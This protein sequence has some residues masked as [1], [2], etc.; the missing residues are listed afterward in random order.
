MVKNYLDVALRSCLGNKLFSFINLFGLAV[1][2]ASAILIGLYVADELSYDRFHP[3][4]ERV[5]RVGRDIYPRTDFGGLY[6]ATVPPIAAE[7]LQADFPEIELAARAMPI[8]GLLSRGDAEFYENSILYAD[9]EL[10]DII[11]FEW[12]AGDPATALDAP[13]A[14]VL[15]ETL[16]R[17]YFGDEEAFGR[18]LTLE[19]SEDL[20][21]TGIIRD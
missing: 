8:P 7:Q 2:L 18:T 1:G 17:K 20:T 15:T 6:M 21:V 3:D 16:A 10:L 4:A 11:G 12:L 19:N 5:Y 9:P 13:T 14:I